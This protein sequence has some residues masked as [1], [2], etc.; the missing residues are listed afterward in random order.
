MLYPDLYETSITP[1]NGLEENLYS[2][3]ASPS[4]SVVALVSK[5]FAVPVEEL[6][7]NKKKP[8][9]AE[10]LRA[11]AK[12]ARE[13]R[14]AAEADG[15]TRELTSTPLEEALER[16]K[17]EDTLEEDGSKGK[18]ILLGFARIYSGTIRVG[19][20]IACILPKYSNAHPPTHPRNAKH[21]VTAEVQGLYV[22]MGRELVNVDSV[23]AGNV[24]AIKGLEGRV[25]RNATLC[26]PS[27]EGLHNGSDLT[28]LAASAINLGGV[29]K[30]VCSLFCSKASVTN[31]I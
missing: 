10:E 9:T 31:R 16:M 4:A 13:A 6:P 25:W 17:V 15:A 23:H 8:I 1:N 22:M 19:T 30:L 28:E 27:A 12:A 18:E 11:K 20:T 21:I 5:M 2:C 26:S 3:D 24:F 7:E 29:H 14:K